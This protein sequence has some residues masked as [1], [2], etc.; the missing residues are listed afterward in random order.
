MPN[1]TVKFDGVAG[2][3][4][5][6]VSITRLDGKAIIDWRDGRTKKLCRVK[7]PERVFNA[8]A[9]AAVWKDVKRSVEKI[10]GDMEIY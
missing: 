2:L 5:I 1:D 3:K 9:M 7:M 10:L 6:G 8:V 4:S